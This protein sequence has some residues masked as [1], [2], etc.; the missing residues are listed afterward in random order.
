MSDIQS[1]D[2][3]RQIIDHDLFDDPSSKVITRFPPEPNGYLH[4]GHAK[5]I[6]LNFSIADERKGTTYLRFD[7][8]NPIKEDAVFAESIKKDVQWLGF[9][10]HDKLTHASDYF[11]KLHQAA[12]SLI[13][14]NLAYVDSSS[15]EELKSYRG[16]LTKPGTNSPFRDRSIEENLDLFER[17]R[18]G[19]F[20]DG[21]MILRAKIDMKS[22]NM[23][24]RDPAIYRIRHHQHQRTG[25]AWCIYPMYDFAHAL[26]DAFEG[27]TYSLCTL[28]FE[29]HRPLYNWF[30]EKVK[31]EGQPRQIEFSRLN[32]A[33]SLTSKRKLK[34]LIDKRIVDGWD[35]PRLVTI[36]GMRRRGYPPAA[37]RDF[38]QRVGVTKKR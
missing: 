23:N 37:I 18:N 9:E 16:S 2:F 35:D 12:V 30:I 20:S 13:K 4:L 17:M 5:S 25:D 10:W 21:K 11:E 7:D 36:A 28:E 22:P 32:L 19:E 15:P 26:S 8:T 14:N 29:D 27:I 24:L 38:C 31:T 3:I 6:Y 33:Y 34:D 1:K